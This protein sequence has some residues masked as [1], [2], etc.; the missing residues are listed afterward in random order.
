MSCLLSGSREAWKRYNAKRPGLDSGVRK[1][2]HANDIDRL[3]RVRRAKL[4]QERSPC[5]A[6]KLVGSSAI[7]LL[8]LA[9]DYEA[10]GLRHEVRT[11]VSGFIQRHSEYDVRGDC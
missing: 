11:R 7:G 6:A 5:S 9:E 3:T 1:F 8:K 4:K 10:L 2:C